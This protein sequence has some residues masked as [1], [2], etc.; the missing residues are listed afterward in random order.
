MVINRTLHGTSLYGW[1]VFSNHPKVFPKRTGTL[2]QLFLLKRWW[3]QKM[4]ALVTGLWR[5]AEGQHN[6][7]HTEFLSCVKCP[8]MSEPHLWCLAKLHNV[9]L[10]YLGEDNYKL[11]KNIILDILI[12]TSLVVR[13]KNKMEILRTCLSLILAVPRTRV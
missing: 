1:L 11:N 6:H 4:V 10:K 2:S 8:E 5:E 3:Q 7:E 9:F 12:Q 13:I